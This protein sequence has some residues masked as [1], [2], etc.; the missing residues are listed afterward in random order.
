MKK[1]SFLGIPASLWAVFCFILSVGGTLT[2]ISHYRKYKEKWEFFDGINKTNDVIIQSSFTL[3]DGYKQDVKE[4]TATIKK[5][6]DKIAELQERGNFY[7][8]A[9]Q[10]CMISLE[11]QKEK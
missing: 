10:S 6:K 1:E 3:I 5:Q 4:L 7:C 11:K 2:E 8:D 9:Y